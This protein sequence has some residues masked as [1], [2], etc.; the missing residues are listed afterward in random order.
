MDGEV[1]STDFS[2]AATGMSGDTVL[3]KKVDELSKVL[4]GLIDTNKKQ[5]QKVIDLEKKQVEINNR[6]R[7][8][9]RYTSKDCVIIC[10]PPFDSRDNRNVLRNKLKFFENFLNIKLDEKRIKA[11]HKLPGTADN[12]CPESVICKFVTLTKKIGFLV[13]RGILR[14]SRV[15]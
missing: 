13:Q 4:S 3:T 6:L 10:N 11:R 8:Q 12:G 1:S 15:H 9:E 14:K 7:A 2:N 5:E